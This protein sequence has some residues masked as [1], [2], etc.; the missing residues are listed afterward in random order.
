MSKPSP[1]AERFLILG[2]ET[3][4]NLKAYSKAEYLFFFL[5]IPLINILI[6]TLPSQLKVIFELYTSNPTLLAMFL[7]NY[8]H[9]E[10][11]HILK[12]LSG[13]FLAIFIV[14][15]FNNDKK[16]FHVMSILLFLLLPF[17]ASYFSLLLPLLF[18]QFSSNM[19]IRGFSAIVYGFQGLAICSLSFFTK[20]FKVNLAYVIYIILF[21]LGIIQIGLEYVNPIQNG[22]VTNFPA[23][24]I[25]FIFGAFFPVAIKPSNLLRNIPKCSLKVENL[26][27]KLKKRAPIHSLFVLAVIFV[28][29][30]I[31]AVMGPSLIF[32]VEVP[33]YR[34]LEIAKMEITLSGLLLGFTIPSVIYFYGKIEESTIKIQTKFLSAK[35]SFETL[36][37]EIKEDIQASIESL[38]KD[39]DEIYKGMTRIANNFLITIIITVGLFFGSALSGLTAM[40]WLDTRLIQLSFSLVILG[41]TTLV[42]FWYLSKEFISTSSHCLRQINRLRLIL[43]AFKK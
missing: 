37:K 7:M 32:I 11:G 14:F 36:K 16:I 8:T 29:V 9:S 1:Y 35:R 24:L 3:L 43:S 39:F 13:Y 17:I 38:I 42:T 23:H 22:N 20:R 34:L 27:S 19:P 28:I 6:F 2:A 25:G 18:A 33:E 30:A 26:L 4:R 5:L 21:I 31:L 41:M 12:N 15:A 10:Q 40:V